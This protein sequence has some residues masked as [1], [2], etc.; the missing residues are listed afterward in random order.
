MIKPP[1]A[2]F[3]DFDTGNPVSEVAIPQR[4]ASDPHHTNLEVIAHKT[5]RIA[6]E[7][8][9]LKADMNKAIDRIEG[10]MRYNHATLTESIQRTEK[11]VIEHEE[12]ETAELRSAL[13]AVVPDGDIEGHRRHHEALIKKAEESAEFWA[14]MRKEIVK[15][16]LIG[17]IGWAGFYLWQAFLL[18]PK[19]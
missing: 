9:E 3:T 19:K 6:A 14:T 13:E 15:Y 2:S 12:R 10:S 1:T 16:G 11:K 7:I 8:A 4:R 17:F 18:G 5:S